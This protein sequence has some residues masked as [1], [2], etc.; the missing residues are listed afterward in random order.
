MTE[1]AT[2]LKLLRV[3]LPQSMPPATHTHHAHLLSAPKAFA[4]V[5]LSLI[6][7]C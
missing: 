6:L 3:I 2:Q 7:L 1:K 5:A 4:W